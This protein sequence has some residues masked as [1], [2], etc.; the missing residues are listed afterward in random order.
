MI[1]NLHEQKI[2]VQETCAKSNY[3]DKKS[4]TFD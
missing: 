4:A 1:R 3:I 2:K